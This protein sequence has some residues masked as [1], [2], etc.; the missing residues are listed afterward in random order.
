MPSASVTSDR[1]NPVAAFFAVTVT[2]GTR[3]FLGVDDASLDVAR[4]LL[5]ARGVPPAQTR[6]PRSS[7]R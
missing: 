5:R 1:V 7:Q 2:P 3:G 4:R 6:R